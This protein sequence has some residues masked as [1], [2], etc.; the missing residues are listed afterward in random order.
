[1]AKRIAPSILSAD[2]SKLAAEV[3]AV[4][5][6]GADWLHIDVM[7]GHFVPNITIGPPVVKCLKKV[8][9]LPLDVHLMIENPQDYVEAFAKAGA[10]YLTVHI[11][12]TKDPVA[13][14]KK[15]R[16]LGCRPGITLKPA[17]PLAEIIS[18]LPH[19]DLVLIMTVNPGFSGQEFMHD[20]IP[21]LRELRKA[22]DKIHSKALIEVDG[23]INAE[24]AK[25]CA[26]AD[27]LVSGN[28]IFKNNYAASIKALKE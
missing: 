6:A 12:A 21:K 8:T 15:I 20:Q 7:D 25:L 10:E 13:L 22:L 17:T 3:Q 5:E 14:L 24:T 19:V 16:D 2:F 18:C 4:A 23:G 11:E 27:V 26:V 9:K 1:M 28:F